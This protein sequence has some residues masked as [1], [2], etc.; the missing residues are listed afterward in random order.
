MSNVLDRAGFAAL[1]ATIAGVDPLD[2]E[3][4]IDPNA[5]LVDPQSQVRIAL[6]L[7]GIQ[8][9]GIDEHR[10]AYGPGGYPANA[11]VTT[12]IGNREVTINMKVETYDLGIEAQE[13]L[14]RIRTGIRSA[15]STAMLNS[16]NLAFEWAMKTMRMKM[17]S[18]QRAVSCAVC[19]F[20]FGGIAQQVSDVNLGGGWI[21][22]VNTDDVVPGTFTS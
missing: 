20:Q 22:H 13:I 12:E 10:V 7:F 2:V 1:V 11:L 3:W 6:T 16:L 5:A 21:E 15:A 18:E 8:A 14:D 4:D 9:Q 17:T 19:D